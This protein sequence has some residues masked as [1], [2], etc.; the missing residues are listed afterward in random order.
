MGAAGTCRPPLGVAPVGKL[1]IKGRFWSI[2]GSQRGPPH[3]DVPSES[4]GR[5]WSPPE[6]G[7]PARTPPVGR[8]VVSDR[9]LE[10]WRLPAWSPPTNPTE[11]SRKESQ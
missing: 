5:S 8:L 11:A 1:I 2:C 9:V 7:R 3:R 4:Q 6:A 10:H